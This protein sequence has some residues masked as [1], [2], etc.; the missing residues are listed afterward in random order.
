[1]LT[2]AL[3]EDALQ[4]HERRIIRSKIGLLLH[5]GE[6]NAESFDGSIADLIR[7]WLLNGRW[8]DARIRLA[9]ARPSS[10]IWTSPC[11]VAT[12]HK[13]IA[14]LFR[15]AASHAAARPRTATKL[16]HPASW[17]GPTRERQRRSHYTWCHRGT[18]P[19]KGSLRNGTTLE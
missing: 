1:M 9:V 4:R 13:S 2:D 7:H 10:H 16:F 19:F 17:Q 3:Q 12:S 14:S 8:F 11:S 18:C 6:R 15:M 5:L